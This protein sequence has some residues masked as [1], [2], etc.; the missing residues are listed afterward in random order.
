[1]KVLVLIGFLSLLVGGC[2]TLGNP[3]DDQ[4]VKSRAQKWIDAV[5]DGD[6]E[7]AYKFA[8]PGYR[9]GVPVALFKAKY[10]GATNWQNVEVKNVTCAESKCEVLIGFEY[11]SNFFKGPMPSQKNETWILVDNDWWLYP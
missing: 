3:T 5:T 8:S 1:M 6:F 9:A 4:V 11:T 2:A 7:R 10:L